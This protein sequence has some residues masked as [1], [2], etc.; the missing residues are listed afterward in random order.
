LVAVVVFEGD[1]AGGVG[2]GVDVVLDGVVTVTVLWGVVLVVV[3][4]LAVTLWTGGVPGGSI[5]AGGVPGAALT[6]KVTVWPS[7]RVAVTV[8]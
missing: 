5:W 3:W 1:G 2:V 6:V 4:Q 7:S 8:H